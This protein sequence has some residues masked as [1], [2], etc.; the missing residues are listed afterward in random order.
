MSWASR[1]ALAWR[2]L[3]SVSS[4]AA[5]PEAARVV[6]FGL[7]AVAAMIQRLQHGAVDAEVREHAHQDDEG[8][9]DPEFRLGEHLSLSF[10]V[11]STALFTE[12]RS[13]ATP[14]SRCTIAIAASEA[15]LR[16]LLIAASRVAPMV[17]S[18]SAS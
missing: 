9:G 16:T 15:M 8:D 10:N 18:A 7:D 1:S 12:R 14:V 11:A 2:D 17:F 5:S 6:E 3:Y 4:L 13:G